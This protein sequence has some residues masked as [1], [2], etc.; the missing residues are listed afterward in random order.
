MLALSS[1]HLWSSSP[2]LLLVVS[3][4]GEGSPGE[5]L[6]PLTTGPSLLPPEPELEN[7]TFLPPFTIGGEG[8]P[9]L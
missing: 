6:P 8:C 9:F 7:L 4:G 1:S 3:L 2:N 5:G